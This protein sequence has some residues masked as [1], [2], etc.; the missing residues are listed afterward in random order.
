[1]G[2]TKTAL[3]TKEQNDLANLAK[4]FAHP[5]RVAILEQL[6]QKNTCINTSLVHETGLAQATISQ[7]LKALK[8]AGLI[9]GTIEGKSMNYCID[10]NNWRRVE[11]KMQLFFSKLNND[12][13]NDCC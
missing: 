5:A 8:D 3:F 2:I 11:R 4:C 9:K 1:M 10:I 12:N 6:M 13:K 7:H